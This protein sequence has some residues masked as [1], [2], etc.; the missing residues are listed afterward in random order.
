LQRISVSLV[1]VL[2]QQKE[3]KKIISPSVKWIWARWP[4]VVQEPPWYM[5]GLLPTL[6]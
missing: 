4:N 5:I 3:N 2:F 1:I 6:R